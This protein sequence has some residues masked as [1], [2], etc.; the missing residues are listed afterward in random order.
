MS[1]LKEGKLYNA[2]CELAGYLFS[3]DSLTSEQVD[4]EIGNQ[5][6]YKAVLSLD[7]GGKKK[8]WL[9]TCYN[10]WRRI[11]KFFIASDGAAYFGPDDFMKLWLHTDVKPA[12]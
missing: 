3:R 5:F 4:A 12:I 6:R 7:D 8:T 10:I 2:A 1:Y 9:L 11:K